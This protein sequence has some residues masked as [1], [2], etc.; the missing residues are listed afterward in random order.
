MKTL[1]RISYTKLD[2]QAFENDLHAYH[3]DIE[4]YEQSLVSGRVYNNN[5]CDIELLVNKDN[6]YYII[7]IAV[8]RENENNSQVN[9]IK[10]YFAQ[11]DNVYLS[12]NGEEQ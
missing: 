8:E 1:K 3:I 9:N 12:V 7:D 6:G 2:K 5:N 11:F 4:E 10:K